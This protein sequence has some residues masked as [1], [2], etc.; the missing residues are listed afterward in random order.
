MNREIM[1]ALLASMGMGISAEAGSMA[2]EM[3]RMEESRRAS[4]QIKTFSENPFGEFNDDDV[5]QVE[6]LMYKGIIIQDKPAG[7]IKINPDILIRL[8]QEGV[9]KKDMSQEPTICRG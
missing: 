4:T 8:E 9:L 2:D 6:E 3:K 5:K 7:T 1:Y